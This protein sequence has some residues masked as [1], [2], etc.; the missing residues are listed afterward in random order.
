MSNEYKFPMIL[1]DNKRLALR[2]YVSI[3]SGYAISII[4]RLIES[5]E[6]ATHLIGLQIYIDV[7]AALMALSKSK[8]HP[9]K[10][11]HAASKILTAEQKTDLFA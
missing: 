4:N 8:Y 11:A 1:Q 9:R 5:G 3:Y 7:D 6:I 10:S 2:H